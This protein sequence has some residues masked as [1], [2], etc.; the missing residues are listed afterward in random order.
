LRSAFVGLRKTHASLV[1]K[2]L[3]AVGSDMVTS[4]YQ[5]LMEELLNSVEKGIT[6]NP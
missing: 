6:G 3:G 5:S 1:L 2:E 4:E